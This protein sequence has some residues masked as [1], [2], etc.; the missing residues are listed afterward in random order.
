MI[1]AHNRFATFSADQRWVGN[2]TALQPGEGYL[3]RR[4][5]P[6]SVDIAFFKQSNSN[7]P[8][9]APLSTEGASPLSEASPFSNPNAA[10][11]MTIIA[12]VVLDD[13][14]SINR[15][16]YICPSYIKV[17]VS[18]DLAAVATPIDS[19]YFI[20]IQSD[21]IGELR[22]EMDGE[23]LVPSSINRTSYICPSSIEYI[24]DSHLGSL[25]APVL[26][27]PVTGNPSPVT[28]PYK[29]IENDHVVII[30][31]NEKYDVTGKKL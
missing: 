19:L 16:S 20:T 14:S 5:A 30:R 31:N 8:K 28:A 10:T 21:R 7:A 29:I 11:N 4:L 18:D 1:K 17:F 26:L 13:P 15:T 27:V 9:R 22:F 3:F 24:P 23:T 25:K 6:G 2:L 12:K